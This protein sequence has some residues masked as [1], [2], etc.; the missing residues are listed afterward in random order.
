MSTVTNCHKLNHEVS[1]RWVKWWKNGRPWTH[2]LISSPNWRFI[3]QIR[4]WMS[5]LGKYMGSCLDRRTASPCG[6][7]SG[8]F[9]LDRPW[10]KNTLFWKIKTEFYWLKKY[11]LSTNNASDSGD[12]VVG[13]GT[14]D[15]LVKFTFQSW[16]T[17]NWGDKKIVSKYH[18]H[19][20]LGSSSDCVNGERLSEMTFR[21]FS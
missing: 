14:Q 18:T 12:K 7:K 4:S 16:E 19:N 11:L 8:I 3:V 2:P 17:E 21:L 10:S 13:N 6:K 1:G 9:H 15:V 20:E 5:S